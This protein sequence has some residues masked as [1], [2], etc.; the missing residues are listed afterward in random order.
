MGIRSYQSKG[1]RRK[2]CGIDGKPAFSNYKLSAQQGRNW[3]SFL[4]SIRA[5][6]YF[7]FLYNFK[8]CSN[9]FSIV[10]FGIKITLQAPCKI[11]FLTE[12]AFPF[13]LILLHATE[14]KH[15]QSLISFLLNSISQSLHV[16]KSYPGYILDSWLKFNSAPILFSTS[17]SES[18][19]K[20]RIIGCALICRSICTTTVGHRKQ[21]IRKSERWKVRN[22]YFQCAADL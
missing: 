13:S 20:S 9:L 4:K 22:H 2:L 11:S 7:W 12:M 1:N 3:P 19:S 14:V 6:V 8:N 18:I 15:F 17:S 16:G 21:V 10:M 5:C